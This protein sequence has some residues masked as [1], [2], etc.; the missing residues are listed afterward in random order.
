[1]RKLLVAALSLFA[2]ASYAQKTVPE[3][4][5]P[6]VVKVNKERPRAYFMSYTNRDVAR[7]NDFSKSDWIINLN[8]KWNFQYLDDHKKVPADFM[9]PSFDDSKWDKITVPGNWERQ[10]FGTAI[11]TNHGYE[12]KPR[13]PT[14][15]VLPAAVPTGLYR[16][17]FHIPLLVRD[18]DVFLDLNGVKSGTYIYINGKKVGYTED[19]KSNAEFLIN[20]YIK[21]G[22]NTLALEVMRWSTGS[23]LECQD[24]WRISGIERDVY[25][26]SQPKTRLEDFTVISTLDSTYTNGIFKLD[27][28]LVNSFIKKSGPM[29]IWYELEDADKNLIDYSYI[30]TELEGNS[31]D[32]ARFERVYKNVHKW[33]AEDPYLYTLVMKIRKEGNF[34]E[35]AS[36]K[37]GFRTSEVKGNL[38]LVN[39]KK[40]FIK[41]VNYHEHNETTGHY[42]TEDLIRRDMELMKQ[43]NINAIRLCHYPQSRRF[44]ELADEYGFYLCNEA[45]IESHGMYYN[46]EKGGTLG[47]NPTWLNAHMERT[48]N[49]YEQAKNYPSVMFWSLGNEAGNGYNFYETYRYLKSKDQLRP[50]QYERALLEWNTDIYCP[51]YPG[52]AHFAAW[53]KMA[54]DRPYIASEYA[55][56]MGNSTG[57]FRDQWVEIYKSKNLQ[58]GFIWDWVDQG[59]LETNKDGQPYWNYGGDYG[60]NSPSDGNFLCNGIVSPDRTPKPSLLSEIKKVHQYVQFEALDIAKGE[61]QIKNIYDFTNLNKYTVSWQIMAS[62]K[63]IRS[64]ALTLDMAPDAVRTI[65][66]PVADLRAA[67]GVEYFV[68]FAVTLKADDGLLKKGDEVASDQF[69]LPITADKT[70]YAPRGGALKVGQSSEVIDVSNSSFAVAIDRTTGYMESYNINGEEMVADGFGLRPSF[71]RGATDNDYGSQFPAHAAAWRDPIKKAESVRVVSQSTAAVVVEARYALPEKTTLTVSY[72]IL[73]SGA[74]NVQ[75]SFNGNPASKTEIMRV[76]MRMRLPEQYAGLEYFGRGPS[77]NYIDRKWGSDVGL[78]KSNAAVENYDYVRPQETGHHTDTRYLSL[79]A[80]RKGGVAVVAD[81]L[82]EFNA[83]RNS[84]ENF[85]GEGHPDK[86]YQWHNF[87]KNEVHNQEAAFGRMPR[88]THLTD[89]VPQ[90]YVELSIDGRMAGLAGDDSWGS[91]PYEQYKV[92]VAKDYKWGFTLL[93][94]KSAAETARYNGVKF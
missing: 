3:W 48:Q 55:H 53:A 35:Y 68:N 88:H 7:D 87:T 47:N 82:I 28:A 43:A 5:D 36:A 74:V 49:M 34:I 62:G 56:A 16:T 63:V 91:R 90:P 30:E 14:P 24:F 94:V 80:Q 77:E 19:S 40:V 21:E 12:F 54:T 86:S 85:D 66:V 81:D 31:R 83:L 64:Q 60:V 65:K 41:G 17:T 42:L 52:A 38:Y 6:E 78:Y 32:T 76:G 37:V 10:G 22:T 59:F 79:T 26:W 70:A 72:K 61:F 51:Q 2:I 44:F 92:R 73:P 13:N 84:V 75:C 45:N 93:P 69:L 27:M 8:G 67:A 33:S 1:M 20:D 29:Q 71:W 57:N 46:L 58:G 9:N 50:V 4:Q 23:Y 18:R 89:I 11:Y 39:G 15:P 25:I